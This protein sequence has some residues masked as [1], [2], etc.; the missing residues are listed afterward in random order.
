[1]IDK[2]SPQT[3]KLLVNR[4]DIGPDEVMQVGGFE[5]SLGRPGGLGVRGIRNWEI[6]DSGIRNLGQDTN[7]F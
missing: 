3:E 7:S 6:R 1:M 4:K 5:F 2:T